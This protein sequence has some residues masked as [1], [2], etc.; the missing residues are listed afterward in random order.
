[1]ASL[2]AM[3]SAARGRGWWVGALQADE[4]TTGAE[5]RLWTW[6]AI[7]RGARAISIDDWR[8]LNRGA[9]A[10]G[11]VPDRVRAAGEAAGVIGRN[12]SLFGLL[13]PHAAR[14]AI[15]RPPA[16]WPMEGSGAATSDSDGALLDVYQAFFDRNIQVD[17][18][19]PD[20]IAGGIAS[21]YDAIDAGDRAALSISVAAALKGFVRDGGTLIAEDIAGSTPLPRS[22]GDRRLDDVFASG[23]PWPG[24]QARAPGAAAASPAARDRRG[25]ASVTLSAYGHGRAFLFR[26]PAALAAEKDVARRVAE[27]LERVGAAGIKPEVGIEGGAGLVEARFLESADAILLVAMNHGA[28]AQ[29]VTFAFGPDVPEAIWQNMET[30]A[31][32]NFVQTADGPTYTRTFG[33][34]DVMV[35]VRGKRLR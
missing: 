9:P 10:D 34:R 1:M 2:D 13:R 5:L 23:K 6:A 3:R 17:F 7:S 11:A 31:A 16:P 22:G 21:R 18:V 15:L 33:G 28:A 26:H 32:V 8:G 27:S 14:M 12:G 30:G 25:E 35:L 29:K 20:E 4:A 19:H 24:L